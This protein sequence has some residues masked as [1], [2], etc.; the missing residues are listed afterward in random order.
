[1]LCCCNLS[2]FA[3]S[4]M[5]AMVH[6][7]MMVHSQVAVLLHVG[8]ACAMHLC[9]FRKQT[10]RKMHTRRSNRCKPPMSHKIDRLDLGFGLRICTIR[11]KH[12]IQ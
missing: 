12:Q 2:F 1:M 11:E 3:N 6:I 4:A 8:E 9:I 7:C 10:A 5:M